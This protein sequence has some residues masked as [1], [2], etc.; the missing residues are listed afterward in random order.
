M[1]LTGKC[2]ED[3]KKW[4]NKIGVISMFEESLSDSMKYGVLVDFF[5]SVGLWV[6]SYRTSLGCR[7]SIEV[8]S[9]FY[10]KHSESLPEARTEAIKKAVIIYNER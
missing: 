1:N 9:N 4:F 5:D 10:F 2:L 3:F 6:S 8:G 7:Y